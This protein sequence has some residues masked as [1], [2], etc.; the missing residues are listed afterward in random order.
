MQAQRSSVSNISD[1]Y[2]SSGNTL[3]RRSISLSHLQANGIDHGYSSPGAMAPQASFGNE[4]HHSTVVDSTVYFIRDCATSKEVL[5]FGDVEP[6]SVSNSPRLSGIWHEA[7]TK[8][9]TGILTGMFIECSYDDSQ[10]DAVLFGHM[11]PRHIVA[12]LQSLAELVQDEKMNRAQEKALR[13]RKRSSNTAGMPDSS[14]LNEAIEKRRNMGLT[15]ARTP[16]TPLRRSSISAALHEEKVP[17]PLTLS[18]QLK[19]VAFPPE[20]VVIGSPLDGVR[21]VIIHV[22]DTLKDGPHISERILRQ[23]NDHATL[24]EEAGWGRLGCE[25]IVSESGKDYYF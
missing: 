1:S 13:K 11:A 2:I 9:A 21:I 17:S 18:S 4:P 6:D 10:P 14:S 23:L 15:G 16:T 3:D 8:I 5:I 22:K 7:A 25:F 19:S 24:L 12:E 20:P